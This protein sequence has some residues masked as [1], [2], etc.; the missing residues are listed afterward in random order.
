MPTLTSAQQRL[1][2]AALRLFAERGVTQVNVSDLAQ[3]AGVARGT[4]YNNLS[5]VDG[6][7]T[8][9]AARLSSD[10][11]DKIA[12]LVRDID[13]PAERLANGRNNFV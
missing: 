12:C 2:D 11:T 5:D 13:D 1:Y 7:F 8:D 6:L 3:A 10:M 9:V 4:V